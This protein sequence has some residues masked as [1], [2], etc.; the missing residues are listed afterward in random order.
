M[1]L[2]TKKTIKLSELIYWVKKELL[3]DETLRNDPVPLFIIEEVTVEVNFILS[4]EGE[5]GFDLQV[6]KAGAKI[7]EERVQKAIV[8]M[9]PLISSERLRE[10]LGKEQ[11]EYLE[12]EGMKVML[13]GMALPESGVPSRE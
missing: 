13:K 6:V 5:G 9:K 3:S 4:G 12:K 11:I 7:A 10:K 1:H 8:R 2:D